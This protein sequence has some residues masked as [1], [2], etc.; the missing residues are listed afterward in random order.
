V[1]TA[2]IA[3]G[4]V[5]VVLGNQ[6]PLGFIPGTS[7]LLQRAFSVLVQNTAKT[8]K[9]FRLTIANQ[10]LLANGSVDPVG[11][12][13]FRQ[14][15]PTPPVKTIDVQIYALSSAA[16][17]VFVE[18]QNP[19]ASIQVNVQEIT[20]PG[21]TVISGGL[22]GVAIINPDP[23]TP[24]LINPDGTVG[25]PSVGTAEVYNPAIGNPAIGNPAIGNPAIG[26]PAIGNPAIGNPAIG[27]PAIGN[28]AYATAL[29]PAIG[30]PAIGNPAIGNPAIGNPA[31]GN[32]SVT[33]ASYDLTNT[34]NTTASYS[35]K[36]FGS[37]AIPSSLQFQLILNKLYYLNEPGG[38]DGCTLQIMPTNVILSNVP[39][40][41]IITDPNTLGNPAIGN[42]AIGNATVAVPPNDTVQITLRVSPGLD[43]NGHPL[44]PL[45]PQQMQ[46]LVLNKITP[47]AVSQAINTTDLANGIT[48]PPIS[49]TILTK[50]LPNAFTSQPYSQ[51][52]AA[53]GGVLPAETTYTWSEV[54]VEVSNLP[55]GLSLSPSGLIS[56]TPTTGGQYNFTIQVADAAN[57]VHTA[58]QAL[59]I[60]VIAPLV[61]TPPATVALV[62]NQSFSE[63]LSSYT[64]GG[65]PPYSYATVG[66]ALPA[67]FT[68]NGSV[69]SGVSSVPVFSG[70][71]LQVRDAQNTPA[72]VTQPQTISVGNPVTITSITPS[73]AASGF[74]QTITIMT[75]GVPD[76]NQAS[77]TFQGAVSG[78]GFVFLSPSSANLLYVRLPSGIG[79]GA[80][81]VVVTN[82]A[83]N[84]SSAPAAI[85]VSSTP[86]TPVATA[87]YGL[88]APPSADNNFC[89]SG[90]GSVPITTASEGQGIA[91]SAYGIDTTNSVVRFRQGDLVVLAN[92]GCSL[93][94]STFGIAVPV[95]V[96]SRFSPSAPILVSIQTS[97]SNFS[98][99][100]SNEISLA[101]TVVIGAVNQPASTVSH[102][103][104][105]A[106]V[107]ISR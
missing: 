11:S 76:P 8:T 49:L 45:T 64:S 100:W 50:S 55:P 85:T 33:D 42:P 58:T 87:I 73:T 28:Q 68:L 2:R 102:T 17:D 99:T 93:S 18:S 38:V 51:Q 44:P 71:T 89:G 36:L 9:T 22:S 80:A 37:G 96:P 88:A 57:P 74:G 95:T 30:N 69:I 97:V 16:R 105:L 61:F 20:A 90:I 72:T 25:N 75:T 3:P 107:S 101:P 78:Q 41:P 13:T 23:T 92:P 53:I 1:Y 94:N 31:I 27:N 35:V 98:S 59:S 47:V 14:V 40:P 54:A 34:G 52:L 32:Q 79:T 84:I 67:G 82:T 5:V 66:G 21:G 103:L 91:V 104:P 29:N 81:S 15:P 62:P 48:Q 77:V 60:F 24:P 65:L 70:F 26:N 10:P 39:N 12:A 83:T 56:G 7:T 6:K 63:N 4:V 43:A 19:T 86:G 106:A 46:S